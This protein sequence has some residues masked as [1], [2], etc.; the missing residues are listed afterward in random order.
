MNNNR[1][2]GLLNVL[3]I[4]VIVLALL[5]AGL[6]AFGAWS[7]TQVQDYKV[8]MDEKVAAQVDGVKEKQKKELE[9][10]FAEREKQPTR[11][12]SSPE[13]LGT[14]SVQYPK[15]WSV[16]IDKDGSTSNRQFEA[17]FNPNAVT[18][19]TGGKP[20]A[21]RVSIQQREYAQILKTFETKIKKGELRTTPIKLQY[22]EGLR[23]DGFFNKDI[24]GSLIMFTLRDKTVQ[25][26]TESRAFMNDFDKIVLPSLTFVP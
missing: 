20:D 8:N 16:Y 3:L 24:E 9:E 23:L 18:P 7:Y 14:V 25:I 13:H 21:L 4:P 12:F 19:V 11:K 6:G 2:A 17:Y 15:T 1:Q 22:G 26:S 5:V 10:D